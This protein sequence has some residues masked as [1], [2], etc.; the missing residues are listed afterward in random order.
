[1]RLAD[2]SDRPV[3]DPRSQNRRRCPRR[4]RQARD[5][6]RVLNT[7]QGATRSRAACRKQL[8]DSAPGSECEAARHQR[9]GTLWIETRIDALKLGSLDQQPRS[10]NSIAPAPFETTSNF[11]HERLARWR[12]YRGRPPFNELLKLFG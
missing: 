10:T 2:D 3:D 4:K 5:A 7:G 12:W 8:T 9:A 6:P 11:E 1:M